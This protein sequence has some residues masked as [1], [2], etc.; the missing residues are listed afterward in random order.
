MKA[1]KAVR[2]GWRKPGF[3]W[4]SRHFD[5]CPD[6]DNELKEAYKFHGY[7]ACADPRAVGD[8]S[9]ADLFADAVERLVIDGV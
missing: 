9:R 3:G 4:R 1:M 8:G 6:L 7:V 2:Q 5:L